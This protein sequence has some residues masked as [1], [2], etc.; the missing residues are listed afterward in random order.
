MGNFW[1]KH[2]SWDRTERSGVREPE[3]RCLFPW[4][5]SWVIL[6][7]SLRLLWSSFFPTNK[8]GIRVPTSQNCCEIRMR[9]DGNRLWKRKKLST[10]YHHHY[11]YHHYYCDCSCY[12]VVILALITLPVYSYCDW[13]MDINFEQH[14]PSLFAFIRERSMSVCVCV[15]ACVCTHAH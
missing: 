14:S 5:T 6:G 15:C 11:H 2:S 13:L 3:L 12:F 7:K 4:F 8:M 1:A 10:A 9:Q